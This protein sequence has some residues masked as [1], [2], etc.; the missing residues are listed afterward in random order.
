M[1]SK[2]HSPASFKTGDGVSLQYNQ[3]GPPR[4]Q[5]LL[6]I[7]GWRQAAAEWRKQAEYFS[8]A[9][10]RVTTF[11]QRGH[12]DSE[13]PDFGYRISRL[14]ADLNDLLTH[15]DLQNVTI[16]GHSM[17]CSVSWALWDQFPDSH[18][19]VSKFVFV[20][21]SPSMVID[22]HWNA[23]ETADA[24][25]LF[26][27]VGVYDL[28]AG[29]AAQLES[30]VTSMFTT[31]VSESDLAWV[32]EQNKKM[33]DAHAAALLT[34]HSFRDWRDVIPRITVPTLVIGGEASLV[35]AAAIEWIAKQIPGAKAEIFTK[36]EKGSHFM[37]WENPEKF[38]AVVK[39]F[40]TR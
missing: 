28:A 22:P 2:L 19:R 7:T 17:G 23:T 35:P 30:L 8:S 16:I 24:G 20:D 15:L 33:S 26:T 5:P 40:V 36:A 14:A 3:T 6:F 27:P 13:G 34:D 12:G 29:M 32:V 31:S 39:E 38:N 11:D 37:F 25:A 18:K 10:F 21:Q 9:G 1:A 4:G